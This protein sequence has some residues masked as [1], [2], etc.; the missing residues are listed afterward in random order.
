MKDEIVTIMGIGDI[1]IDREEPKSIFSHTQEVL[2][3]ADI[4]FAQLEQMY[5][6]K[7]IRNPLVLHRTRCDP[8]NIP[9]LTYAGLDVVSLA[10]NHT[11][12]WGAEALLD[13]IERLRREGMAVIGVGGNIAEARCPAILERKGTR[14]AFLGYSSMGPAGYE[15][16][17]RWPGNAPMR[18]WTHYEKIDYQPGSLPQILT[19]PYNEDLVAMLEDIRQ[20]K[21]QADVVVL[22]IHWGVHHIPAVIPMYEFQVAHAAID[23]G[24]DLILGH[25]THILKGVEVYRGKAIF[26][27]LGNFALDPNV[28]RGLKMKYGDDIRM[29]FFQQQTKKLYNRGSPEAK[30]TLIAKV[31]ISQGKVQKVSFLPCYINPKREPEI[32]LRQDPRS[33]E[34]VDYV[35]E[36]S[37]S[38]GLDTEFVWEGNEVVIRT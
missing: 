18:A 9:A 28:E 25:H 12:D 5:S 10:G 8:G 4:T 22:S 14:V 11:L 3:S 15:A 7:G 23:A 26:H 29:Y 33:Q 13:S 6:D 30:R 17:E 16:D 1:I 35:E 31:T 34:V 37:R 27:N 32:L 38:Q 24:V 20:A 36:I 21:A 19:F 2:H